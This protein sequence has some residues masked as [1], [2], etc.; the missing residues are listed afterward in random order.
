MAGRRHLGAPTC[1][2]KSQE[3][4]WLLGGRSQRLF[5]LSPFFGFD[6]FC[7]VLTFPQCSVAG[8][9]AFFKKDFQPT[10]FNNK[11]VGELAVYAWPAGG[12]KGWAKQGK[13]GYLT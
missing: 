5:F 9:V 8:V 4:V 10:I 3:L 7:F 6:F 2:A 12:A 13:Q 11:T 1:L